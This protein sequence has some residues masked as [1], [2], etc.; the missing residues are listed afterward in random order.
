ELLVIVDPTKLVDHL[1]TRSPIPVEVVPYAREAL[2]TE[3]N[4]RGLPTSVRRGADGTGTF[5][6]DNGLEV[7]DLRPSE[8]LEDPARLDA[9]L[10][11]FPGVVETGLFVGLATSVLI[12]RP[13]GSVEERRARGAR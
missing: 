3:L 1:G 12:G 2:L 5:R 8:P 11:G 10:H 4:E 6:T 9:E 7:L 13:D